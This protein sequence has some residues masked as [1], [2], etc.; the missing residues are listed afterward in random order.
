MQTAVLE[1]GN[2]READLQKTWQRP[3]ISCH[4]RSGPPNE[5][6][7]LHRL[8]QGS[9]Q[10]ERGQLLDLSRPLFDLA[11]LDRD[12]VNSERGPAISAS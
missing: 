3:N 10:D 7:F 12:L 8:R 5:R 2:V 1:P 4:F 11:G 9:L 6:A